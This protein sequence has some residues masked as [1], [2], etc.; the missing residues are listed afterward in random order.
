MR[1]PKT[2]SPRSR[3]LFT[4][5]IPF[6]IAIPFY[7]SDSFLRLGLLFTTRI[8][9]TATQEMDFYDSDSFSLSRSKH[10][11]IL[12]QLKGFLF[13]TPFMSYAAQPNTT[14]TWI[15][16]FTKNHDVVG[17]RNYDIKP[18]RDRH[19]TRSIPRAVVKLQN[20]IKANTK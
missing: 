18:L 12:P 4:T 1:I 15:L 6:T 19:I 2:R 13:T 7:D 5:A 20:N 10:H 8:T 17:L 9:T 16:P 11:A 3:S 14:R